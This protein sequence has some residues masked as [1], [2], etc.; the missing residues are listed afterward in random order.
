MLAQIRVLQIVWMV[1]GL[2]QLILLAP[3]L[4]ILRK[5]LPPQEIGGPMLMVFSVAL[6]VIAAVFPEWW[7]RKR[8]PVGAAYTDPE[9]KLEH[10]RAPLILGWVLCE[11]AN[12][13]SIIAFM[14]NRNPVF[15]ALFG[16]GFL[17]FYFRRAD[18]ERFAR[19]YK[20]PL[21]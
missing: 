17:L 8:L 18:P 20:I 16:L 3:G 10:Y 13:V 6:L 15:L 12:M 14:I 11:S 7:Y 2:S 4:Y 1:M 19:D 5:D 21:S 9:K